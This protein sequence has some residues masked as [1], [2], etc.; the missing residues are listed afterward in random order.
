MTIH[1]ISLKGLEPELHFHK[2]PDPD[3]NHNPD[4]DPLVDPGPQPCTANEWYVLNCLISV[5]IKK[6]VKICLNSI[7]D[8][9]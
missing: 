4:P 1:E 5:S 3:Q 9:V 6:N 2:Y 7:R 8:G